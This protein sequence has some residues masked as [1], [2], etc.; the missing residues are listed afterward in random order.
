MTIYI[1]NIFAIICHGGSVIPNF[2]ANYRSHVE[3]RFNFHFFFVFFKLVEN[4][5]K[6]LKFQKYKINFVVVTILLHF[7]RLIPV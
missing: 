2:L 5:E 1:Y 7:V 6:L 3:S 4:L